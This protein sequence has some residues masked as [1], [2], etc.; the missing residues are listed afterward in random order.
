MTDDASVPS[1]GEGPGRRRSRHASHR[2]RGAASSVQRK[3]ERVGRDVGDWVERR[4]AA[5]F[6]GVAVSWYR[7]YRDVDGAFYALAVTAFLFVTV[8][9]AALVLDAY[10]SASPNAA[11]E[12]TIRRLGLSGAS[13]D[14]VRSVLVGAGGHKLQATLIAV[15]SVVV[16]GLGIGRALQLVYGRAWGLEPRGHVVW[17]QARYLAWFFAFLGLIVLFVLQ[18]TFLPAAWIQWLLAPVWA[19]VIIAFFVWTARFLLH[20]RVSGRDVLPGAILVTLGLL[21]LRLLSSVVLKNW[22]DWY[23][24]Y[25]GGL[26]V[27]M[28]I[29]FW[30]GIAASLI[31]AAATLSPAYAERTRALR[32][33]PP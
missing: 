14:L 32:A 25:Y 16:F 26:G 15:F 22:L 31:V 29:F 20:H 1:G 8:L 4:D 30:I 27:I 2:V 3:G 13:E 21:A 24:T 33:G 11:A 28:A 18:V 19:V 6:S 12:A 7:R 5:S 9:P 10:A 17:D 23:S